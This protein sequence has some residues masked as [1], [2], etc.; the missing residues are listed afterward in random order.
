MPATP[1]AAALNDAYRAA[2]GRAAAQGAGQVL[3]AFREIIQANDLDGSF[4]AYGATAV[5]LIQSAHQGASLL[6]AGYYAAHRIASGM[7]DTGPEAVLAAPLDVNQILS[8]LITTGQAAVKLALGN[9][10]EMD[11][12]LLIAQSRTAGAVFRLVANG[13][14]FTVA[15]TAE[16]DPD[17]QRW[18]RVTDG[19]PCKFCQMLAGRGAVYLDRDTAVGR[20]YHDRCGCYAEPVYRR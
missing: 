5:P 17:C 16:A 12:A 4:A 11:Q 3:L 18:R 7:P 1:A 10:S 14:R 19:S 9:G 6:G 13:A 8:A 2:Q 15:N 20:A